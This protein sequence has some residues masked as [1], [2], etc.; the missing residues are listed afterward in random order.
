MQSVRH[1]PTRSPAPTLQMVAAVLAAAELVS[2][3]FGG[4]AVTVS[5]ND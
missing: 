5:D 3:R 4:Y 2:A 1:S